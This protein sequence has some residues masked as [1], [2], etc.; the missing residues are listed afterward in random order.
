MMIISAQNQQQHMNPFHYPPRSTSQLGTT[1]LLA[2]SFVPIDLR[3][4]NFQHVT[5]IIEAKDRPG[6]LPHIQKVYE[7][8]VIT[9]HHCACRVSHEQRPPWNR[10]QKVPFEPHFALG[11]EGKNRASP[12]FA[13]VFKSIDKVHGRNDY[14]NTTRNLLREEH[15]E[16]LVLYERY[17]QYNC[18]VKV[19]SGPTTRG[20]VNAH[21]IFNA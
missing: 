17:S 1:N 20:L 8:S 12:T 16:T 11:S 15:E 19:T 14:I 2:P 21:G 3:R 18:T 7:S 9:N 13:K 4:V 5:F 6:L 10:I